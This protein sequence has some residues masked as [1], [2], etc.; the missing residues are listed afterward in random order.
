MALLL[1][2]QKDVSPQHKVALKREL[3]FF[4]DIDGVDLKQ[5]RWADIRFQRNN[6]TY[7]LLL[8][9][10][11][12]IVEGMLMTTEDGEY[13]L[14]SF[15]DEQKMHRLYEKFILEYYVQEYAKHVKGFFC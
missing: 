14:A 13:R 8:S 11:Q 1:L 3:L 5:V 10:C 2:K 15:I 7:Q 9:I 4:A 12:L 6:R